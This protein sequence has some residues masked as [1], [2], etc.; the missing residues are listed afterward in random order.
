M[1]PA[2]ND[3]NTHDFKF[4]LQAFWRTFWSKKWLVLTP[5]LVSALAAAIGV[6][7]L[8]PVFE[9]TAVLEI[10]DDKF[11]SREMEQQIVQNQDRRRERDRTLLQSMNATITGK[12]FQ[13]EL[14][15]R[16]GLDQL[17]GMREEAE[18][19]RATRFPQMSTEEILGHRLRN[20]LT[21]K[22]NVS[23]AGPRLFR[24]S[25]EDFNAE[26]SYVL[27]GEISDL[28]V[29]LKEKKQLRG[30]QAAREFS[31]EQIAIYKN[32]L[33]RSE[34][35]LE[36]VQ[37][38]LARRKVGGGSINEGNVRT[39]ETLQQQLVLD[40][41]EAR[42]VKMKVRRSLETVAK[43]VPD[44][45]VFQRDPRVPELR[46]DLAARLVEQ[47]LSEIDSQQ[48]GAVE[49]PDNESGILDAKAAIQRYLATM[50]RENY[51]DV[52]PDY[53][54]LLVEYYYQ[55]AHVAS[56]EYKAERLGEYLQRF[57]NRLTLAPEDE[58]ELERLRKEVET[59]R[60]LLESFMRARA[61]TQISEAVQHMDLGYSIN[62][63]ERPVRP[64]GPVRPDKGKIMMLAVLFGAVIGAGGLFI[65][66]YMDSSFSDID[67]V[68]SELDV[69]VLGTLP[70]LDGGDWNRQ[71]SVKRRF[72]WVTASLVV[73]ALSISGFYYFGKRSAR[74]TIQTGI[75]ETSNNDG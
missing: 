60:E 46:R 18:V 52:S 4:D 25:F 39:A 17:E 63:V 44:D 6:R 12:E 35:E 9:S 32:V 70:A 71:S 64:L 31:D 74:D 55:S 40:I 1:R 45:G 15:R 37:K 47:L 51:P 29:E 43:V 20:L 62:I 11:L 22:S 42:G 48:D 73:A 33:T 72:V 21:K 7:F 58:R 54:P 61:Q 23:L 59:N 8:T 5:M 66:E 56:L 38:S 27:A 57:Q 53:L 65:T 10:S 49:N 3:K 24:I 41:S 30:L 69:R 28:F 2:S 19:L 34:Q 67:E 50:V 14:I 13:D 68:E 16:L 26:N 75:V 36:D